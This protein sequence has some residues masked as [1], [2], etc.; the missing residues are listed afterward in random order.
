MAAQ[1]VSSAAQIGEK[2]LAAGMEADVALREGLFGNITATRQ[3]A[4]AALALSTGRDVQ[5]QAALGLAFAG[6]AAKAQALAD[7]L[8][9]RFPQDTIAQFIELP[10]IRG[11]L[12][13]SRGDSSKAIDV[14]RTSAPYDLGGPVGIFL[15]PLYGRGEVYLAAKNGSAAVAEFQKIINH[16]AIVL[17]E[18]IGALA[19]LELGRAYALE[20]QSSPGASVD[21][22]DGE[23]NANARKAY[24]DFF[25]LWQH[26]DPDIPI[27]REAKAE[28]AKLH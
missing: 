15:Y 17:N 20:A 4:S 25:A 28:Y 1:T 16:R 21:H 6:D 19:Q 12:A 9:K 7:D 14:L 3:H 22:A 2:E 18:P 13:L 23:A 27:L 5:F 10:P 26:A 8:A 24:Q 11:Q